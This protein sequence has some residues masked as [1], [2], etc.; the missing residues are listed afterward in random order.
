MLEGIAI[1]EP[2]PVY[3]RFGG[4]K[5]DMVAA[6]QLR[7]CPAEVDISQPQEAAGPLG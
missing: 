2:I 4:R 6:V 5:L 3:L 7:D 1:G